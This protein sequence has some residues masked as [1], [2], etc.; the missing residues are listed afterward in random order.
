MRDRYVNPYTDFGFKKI[1]AED[2]EALK[3]LLNQILKKE[4]R[5]IEELSFE[6]TKQLARF[7]TGRSAIY[8]LYCK[9]KN[10]DHFIVEMQQT[11]YEYFKDRTVYYSTFPIQKEA[12]KWKKDH[13]KK[14]WNFK[15]PR[16]YLIGILDFVFE[17]DKKDEKKYFY[18]IQLSDIETK[19]VFYKKL[20]FLYLEMPKFKKRGEASQ[21]SV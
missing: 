19:K 11:P 4:G 10:G 8:D 9:D 1:L 20:S 3:D 17:E 16:I 6:P 2:K 13:P 14:K 21:E 15:L 18:H 5:D 7:A 12:D